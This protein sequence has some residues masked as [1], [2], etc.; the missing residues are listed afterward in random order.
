MRL[1]KRLT[2]WI[3]TLFPGL[4]PRFELRAHWA[5]PGDAD[6]WGASWYFDLLRQRLEPAGMVDDKTWV[7]LEFPRFFTSIDTTMTPVG[8]QC[9]FAQLRS[10]EFD[11]ATLDER[12]HAYA[13]LQA[14]Q[15]LREDL[16]LGLKPL[17]LNAGKFRRGHVARSGAEKNSIRP[18][19]APLDPD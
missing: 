9:L 8:R 3:W 18:T 10:Y 13:V 17:Q 4:N 12:N 2:D 11:T 5:K 15:R 16:Q 7:D 6:G 1:P 14:N 19:A